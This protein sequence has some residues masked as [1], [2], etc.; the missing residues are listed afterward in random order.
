MTVIYKFTKRKRK[1]LSCVHLLHKAGGGGGGE[2]RK[3]YVAVM[4]RQQGNVHKKRDA[5]AKLLFC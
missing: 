5:R 4:R 2:A 3:F 1:C